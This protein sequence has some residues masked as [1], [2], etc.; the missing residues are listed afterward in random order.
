M[1]TARSR[2]GRRRSLALASSPALSVC[3]HAQLARAITRS[4]TLTRAI[5]H[6]LAPAP[7][8]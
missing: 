2:V 3:S 8:L 6:S 4:V 7:I 1:S 5:A